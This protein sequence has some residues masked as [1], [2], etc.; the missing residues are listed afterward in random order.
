MIQALASAI[1]FS[2]SLCCAF[3]QVSWEK[4]NKANNINLYNN[5]LL[6]ET[7]GIESYRAPI[8]R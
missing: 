6:L 5:I 8:N 1:A 3:I 4:Q 7:S 2:S